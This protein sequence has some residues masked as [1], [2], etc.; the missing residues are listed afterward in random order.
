MSEYE[1][2]DHAVIGR[3]SVN[4]TTTTR[5]GIVVIP[6]TILKGYEKDG[7]SVNSYDQAVT[8]TTAEEKFY[9]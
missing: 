4:L 6:P 3:E 7:S 1:Y 8:L 2:A 5:S 9:S